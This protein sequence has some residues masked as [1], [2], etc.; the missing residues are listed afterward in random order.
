MDLERYAAEKEFLAAEKA[1]TQV[2][3]DFL[4][5]GVPIKEVIKATKLSPEK[6]N[7][8]LEEIKEEQH[9]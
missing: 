1:A 7:E 8:L 4:K 5:A 2:I 9:S 3:K 6:V